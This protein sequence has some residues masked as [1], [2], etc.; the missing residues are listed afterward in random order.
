[1]S[2]FWRYWGKMS[3]IFFTPSLSKY[4]LTLS[5]GNF[6]LRNN[7]EEFFFLSMKKSLVGCATQLGGG[8]LL[9]MLKYIEVLLNFFNFPTW[10][11]CSILTGKEVLMNHWIMFL[12]RDSSKKLVPAS[13]S[14][15]LG[16]LLEKNKRNLKNVIVLNFIRGSKFS[17]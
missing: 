4:T 7:M 11:T 3:K 6:N 15:F 12:D 9:K 10:K 17:S 16:L 2:E 14:Y 13:F 1:M 5:V 8:L